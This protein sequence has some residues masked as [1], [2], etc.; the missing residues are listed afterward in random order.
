MVDFNYN[1]IDY[2]LVINSKIFNYVNV[3]FVG[4]LFIA[5]KKYKKYMNCNKQIYLVEA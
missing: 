5:G 2:K 4:Y 1:G 3:L